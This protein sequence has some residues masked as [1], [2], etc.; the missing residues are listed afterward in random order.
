VLATGV[1]PGG[2]T[3]LAS[4]ILASEVAAALFDEAFGA[5]PRE[6]AGA[7]TATA[8]P[9]ALSAAAI[10]PIKTRRTITYSPLTKLTPE[11]HGP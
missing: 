5:G 10:A 3:S 1:A 7:D 9:D 8:I 11:Y 6:A 2:S 4:S